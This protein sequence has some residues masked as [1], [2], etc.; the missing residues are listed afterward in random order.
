MAKVRLLK[1]ELRIRAITNEIHRLYTFSRAVREIG[2][3]KT[4]KRNRKKGEREK[5]RRLFLFGTRLS[6]FVLVYANI[7]R[8]PKVFRSWRYRLSQNHLHPFDNTTKLITHL[9]GDDYLSNH[10]LFLQ[11]EIYQS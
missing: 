10:T 3:Y 2:E 11:K 9:G 7:Y 1:C 8:N 5:R 4:N 6:V